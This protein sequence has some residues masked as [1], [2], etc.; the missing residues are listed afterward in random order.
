MEPHLLEKVWLCE[1]RR[2]WVLHCIKLC[3]LSC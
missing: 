1:A 3:L 2:G